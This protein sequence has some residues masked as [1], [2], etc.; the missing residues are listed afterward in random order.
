MS[1]RTKFIQCVSDAVLDQLLDR[2]LDKK[3]LNEGEIESVKLKKRADKA[4]EIF[5]MV[6]RKGDEASAILMKGIKDLDS[7][8]YKELD[9]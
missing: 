3:V 8:F 7:F 2:L 4:R 5:D 9:N 1:V 6:K